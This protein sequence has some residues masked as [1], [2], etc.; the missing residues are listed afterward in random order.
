[1]QQ[2]LNITQKHIYRIADLTAVTSPAG[3]ASRKLSRS[4]VSQDNSC[5]HMLQAQPLTG[6]G[7]SQPAQASW[8]RQSSQRLCASCTKGMCNPCLLAAV[9]AATTL[10][11]TPSLLSPTVW[12]G[13]LDKDRCRVTEWCIQQAQPTGVVHNPCNLL[14]GDAGYQCHKSSSGQACTS[15]PASYLCL[16]CSWKRPDGKCKPAYK[17]KLTSKQANKQCFAKPS[18]L[19]GITCYATAAQLLSACNTFQACSVRTRN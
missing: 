18:R 1:M 8:Q 6:S 3:V 17:S 9:I 16:N 2:A 19:Q 11:A 15:R 13:N 10:V 4:S 12:G 14:C 7:H 5:R